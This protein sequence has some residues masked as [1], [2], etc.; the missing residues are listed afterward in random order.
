MKP[1]LIILH[2][3]I[4]SSAQFDGLTNILETHYTVHLMNFEGHGGRKTDQP[5]SI[6]LF[7]QNLFNYTQAH[8]LVN[9][10][11]FGYSMGGYVALYAISHG[12]KIN[13]LMT[14]GTKFNWT[15]E[16]AQH[17]IKM[18]NPELIEEKI[19]KFA[20]YQ[21]SL[22]AP[23]DWKTVMRETAKMMVCL[24]ENPVL[25]AKQLHSIQTSVTCCVGLKD[26]MVSLEETRATTAQLPNGAL[27]VFEDFEHPIEK[28]KLAELAS[29]ILEKLK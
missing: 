11:V 7:S 2:G 1:D 24:G 15:P 8:N 25:T 13:K 26:T 12:L 4:G 17:E 29:Y 10:F 6:E 9:P 16:G 5:Y 19:P 22:H 20:A 23:L 27:H 28:V 3:A 21:H 14:L 18:L